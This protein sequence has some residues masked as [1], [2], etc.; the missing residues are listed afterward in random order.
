MWILFRPINNCYEFFSTSTAGKIR[1]SKYSIVYVVHWYH[2]NIWSGKFNKTKN[3]IESCYNNMWC[4]VQHNGNVYEP[5]KI[6]NIVKKACVLVPTLFGIFFSLLL[7]HA[8]DIAE[9]DIYLH[10]R[11]LGK[12][13]LAN[14]KVKT[15]VRHTMISNI[16]FADDAAVAPHS[17]THL[18]SIFQCMHKFRTHYQ[19]KKTKVLAT[20]TTT[21]N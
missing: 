2:K 7:K 17:P 10:T 8:F 6:R 3:F 9:E 1:R 20:A 18:Q 11:T 16:L 19:P 21:T 13:F 15:K 14:L 5:F 4:T 12:L